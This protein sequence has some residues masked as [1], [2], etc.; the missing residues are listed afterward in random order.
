MHC[1]EVI[2]EKAVCKLYF[3]LEF[4]KPGN[5]D[6]NGEKM[7]AQLIELVIKKLEELYGVQCSAED[8][9]NLDSSTDEKFSRHLLFL[10]RNT[11]FKDNSHV[12]NFV[13]TI[14]QP[15]LESTGNKVDAMDPEDR[16][17]C[18]V[19]QPSKSIVDSGKS[20]ASRAAANETSGN[21]QLNAFR[22]LGKGASQ[23]KENPDISFLVVN[24]KKGGKQ[25][26]VDL[27]VYTKNRNFRLYNSSKAGK[28]VVLKIAGDNKFVPKPAKNISQEEQYFFSSLVCNVRFSASIQ[29]LSCSNPEEKKEMCICLDSKITSSPSADPI[30]GYQSSPYPEIDGFV[31]ALI[32]RDGFQGGIRRWNYFS[33]EE[34]L[35]YDISTYRWCQNIGRAHKSNNIMIL[36]DLKKEVWYQKCYD[37]VCRSESYK[38]ECYP[39]PP[40]VSLTFLFKEEED[41]TYVMDESGNIEEKAKQHS[42]LTRLPAITSLGTVQADGESTEKLSSTAEW[43]DGIED[44]CLLEASEDVELV[45]AADSVVLPKWNDTVEEIPDELLVDALK[46]QEVGMAV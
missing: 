37:P 35:V 6:V 38:S 7:V 22:T 24:D 11:A 40:E 34:L 21:G 17:D 44:A 13:K 42:N 29:I 14:L 15:A 18:I 33:L 25:L 19:S 39:L 9:L 12:G 23:Q 8:V 41:Y 5:P 43:D 20:L 16:A 31:L 30:V 27:G 45:E 28:H 1:Y 10:L 2:P 26:F 36:V 32:N 3:D 4:Y 46:K